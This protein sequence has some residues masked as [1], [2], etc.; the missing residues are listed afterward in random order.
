MSDLP[1]DL[2]EDREPTID[3]IIGLYVEKRDFL[4]A[5]RK[6]FT[7]LERTIKEELFGL[8]M[9]L[10]DRAGQLGVESFRTN[11]GTAYKDIKD[12]ARVAPGPEAWESLTTY[13]RKTGDFGCFTRHLTKTHVKQLLE[14]GVNL[15]E[16]GIEYVEEYTMKVMRPRKT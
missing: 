15:A 1:T 16:I 9:W 11:S 4:D 7:A 10:L 3:E 5:K 14:E 13:A 2:I 8:D 12:Y 6:E